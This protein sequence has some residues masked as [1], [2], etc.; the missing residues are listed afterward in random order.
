MSRTTPTAGRLVRVGLAAAVAGASALLGGPSAHAG[1]R[2]TPPRPTVVLVHGAWADPSSWDGVVEKLQKDGYPVAVLAT[3][4]R[5]LASDSAYV[6]AFTDA[7]PGPVVLVGHSYGGAVVTDAATGSANVQALVYVD[8]F[9]PAAGESVLQLATER[10][11]SALADPDPSQVFRTVPY[12]GGPA[13]DVDLYVLPGAF[14][15]SFA[16]DIAPKKAAVLAAA[17]RP[18]AFSALATPS[19]PPAWQT[20]PS[21]YFLGSLDRVLPP[22]E[23]EFMAERAHAHVVSEPTSHLPMVSD[24]V[25]VAH[26]VEAA[27]T[28]TP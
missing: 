6:R 3:P 19:G 26:T 12:A 15:E 11:G 13:G 18:V 8:G 4:L 24:P 27:A 16:N 2:T 17:Q 22:A 23:Q 21:W 7:V 1:A 5:G 25:D 10:P 14:A 9:A 28:G 20:I